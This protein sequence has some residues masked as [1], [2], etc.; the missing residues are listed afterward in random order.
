MTDVLNR[1]IEE[2]LAC[3]L[4]PEFQIH[5]LKLPTSLTP[6]PSHV[7]SNPKFFPFFQGVLGA[8]DGTHIHASPSEE[9]RASHQNQKGDTS[10][11]VL[12]ACTFQMLF[13]Y[14]LSGWEGSAADSFIYEQSRG[15]R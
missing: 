8:I 9:G 4:H 15:H 6:P 3:M 2:V 1:I 14:V 11:N 7:L 13:C 10:Q 5:F 12:A